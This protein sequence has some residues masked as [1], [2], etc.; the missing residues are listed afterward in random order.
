[1]L[2]SLQDT[3]PNFS[4]QIL[5]RIGPIVVVVFLIYSLFIGISVYNTASNTLITDHEQAITRLDAQLITELN[6]LLRENQEVAN[7]GALRSDAALLVAN[8]V[9]VKAAVDRLFADIIRLN[10]NDY[11]RVQYITSNGVILNEVVNERG[12]PRIMGND[13]LPRTD[14]E[15][16]QSDSFQNGLQS[17][18]ADDFYISDLTLE[19]NADG[20]PIIPL[21]VTTSVYVPV[22]DLV[23]PRSPLGVVRFVI[24]AEPLLQVV[25]NPILNENV[26]R[27]RG[28]YLV[29]ELG[30]VI[31]DS[32]GQSQDYLLHLIGREPTNESEGSHDAVASFVGG[33]S[34]EVTL[35]ANNGTL[36]TVRNFRLGDNQ[37]TTWKL[38]VTEPQNTLLSGFAGTMVVILV[39]SGFVV[40]GLLYLIHHQV[41]PV[42]AP[43]MEV[44]QQAQQIAT[45]APAEI[46]DTVSPRT[47]GDAGSLQISSALNTLSDRIQ[48]LNSEL[49]NQST[50]YNRDMQIITNIGRETAT[51]Y[52]I[53]ALMQRSIE[54]ICNELGFYHAQIFLVDDVRVNAVLVQ[55]RGE[56]GQKLLEQGHKLAVGSDSII[57]QVT[58]KGTPVIV[59]D[60][61][62]GSS[63]HGFNPFLPDTRAE[64]ALPLVIGTDVIGAL[65][66]QSVE[67]DVF[68]EHDL[69]TFQLVADQLAVAIHNAQLRNQSNQ[70]IEQ[71]N[72]LNRQL[73]RNSWADAQEAIGF[74]FNY[75]YNLMDIESG[76]IAPVPEGG[77]VAPIV[78]RGEVI[79]TLNAT[80]PEG[81]S[82][83]EGH[84]AIIRAVA[85]R[86]ALA[87]EN[88]RLFQETQ[89]VLSETEIL[90][91][92]SRKLSE[93]G[94]YDDV[95]ASIMESVAPNA[96][97]GGIWIFD[98]Y[99][100]GD[101]PEWAQLA[102]ANVLQYNDDEGTDGSRLHL[103]DYPI[104]NH[105]TGSQILTVPDVESHPDV[106]DNFYRLMSV[107]GAQSIV[108]IPL[109]VRGQWRGFMTIYFD[110]PQ[111]YSEREKRIYN[112]LIDQAGVTIDNRLLL[113]QTESAL[114]RNAKLYTSSRIINTAQSLQDLVYAAIAMNSST[115]V[116][117]WLGILDDVHGDV[118]WHCD[119]RIIARS[120]MGEVIEVDELH[121]ID[122]PAS[123]PMIYGEPEVVTDADQG[124]WMWETPH[125][126]VSAFPL[127]SDN[128][129]IALFFIVSYEDY[130]LSEEDSEVYR[131]LTGQMSTQVQNSRLLEQTE[132]A[133]AE[134]QRLYIAS[135]A[136]AGATDIDSIFDS[137]AGHLAMPFLQNAGD[138]QILIHL[139]AAH[140]NPSRDARQ[141]LYRYQWR[142]DSDMPFEV[143][144]GSIVS[145]Q[146]APFAQLFDTRVS[147]MSYGHIEEELE[148]NPKL[149][150][151]LSHDGAQ[152]AVVAVL[153]TRQNW[154]G[155]LVCK[156]NQPYTFDQRY[157]EFVQAVANQIAIGI[158]NQL[159]FNAAQSERERLQTI[160][161][162]LPTGVIV[163]DPETFVPI[164]VNDIIAQLFGRDVDM[165]Q[166]F[167]VE[168]YNLYRTGT[169]TFYPEGE[170]PIFMAARSGLSEMADDL[171]MIEEDYHI[172]LLLNAAPIFD[173]DGNQTAIVAAFQDIRN[174]RSLEQT[175]QENLRTTISSY[176]AQRSFAQADT[177]DEVINTIIEQV[178]SIESDNVLVILSDEESGQNI[179]AHQSDSAIDDIRGL[180]SVLPDNNPVMIDNI[181]TEDTLTPEAKHLFKQLSAK[182]VMILP[183]R[184][185]RRENALGWIVL[186]GHRAN[187][188]SS[189]DER[190]VSSLADMARTAI[191]NRYLVQSTQSAL[192]ETRIL[193]AATTTI[194]GASDFEELGDAIEQSIL[195]LQPDMYAAF[196]SSAPGEV[197][198]MF[199]VGFEASVE[200][201]M[202]LDV[203]RTARLPEN[204][205]GVY[206]SDITRTTLGDFEKELLN[207]KGIQSFAAV[208]LRAKDMQNGRILLGFKHDRRFTE[209]ETRYL[210]SIADSASVVIDNQTLLRQIQSTLQETSVL[211]QSSRAL[212]DA[213]TPSEI[214]DVV[215]NY[216]I[217]PHVNQVFVAVLN[218]RSWDLPGATV[219]IEAGWQS[220][221]GVN[222]EGVTLSADQFP[223]WEQ[224]SHPGILMINDIYDE[225][226]DLDIMQRTSIE[227]L[228]TRS[229]VIIPLRVYNRAIGSIWIG[230]RDPYDYSDADARIFQAFAESASLSLEA[231]YLFAQTEHRARQ[232]ETSAQVGQSIGQILDLNVLLPEVVDLIRE[233]FK[234]DHVQIFLMDEQDKYAVLEA[235]TGE[236]GR[237]LLAMNHKLAKGSKSVIGQVTATGE[238][239][240]ALDT[241][242]ANV[243][244]QPNQVLPLTRSEMALPLIVK[245]RV[246]G[247]L[248]VQSNQP[249]A[250]SDE[251]IRALTTLA[252][253]IAIAIDNA[254]LY[255]EIERRA[256]DMSLLFETSVIA[257]T[258][259]TL[260]DALQAVTDNLYTALEASAV[261]FYL[262]QQ[263]VNYVVLKAV[264][265]SGSDQPISELSE[266]TVGDSE[267]LIGTVGNTLSS[268]L[269]SNINDEVRYLSIAPSSSTAMI[270]PISSG[271]DLIGLIV[272]EHNR[273]NAFTEEDLQLVSTLAGSLGAIVENSQLLDEL[274]KTN[275]QLREVDRLKSQFLANM[276][277]ELRTPLNSII[278]FSRVMLKGI[279]GALTEM[280]EQDLTTIYNSG[281]HLL[282]LI[283]DILDQAKIESGK[284]DL[285]FAFFGVKT[286]IESVRSIGIGLVKEKPVDLLIDLESGLPQAYGDEFRTRQILLNIVSNASKFTQDGAI[287]IRAYTIET[288]TGQ[289]FIRIDVTDTG[290]GID[291][292]DIPLLFET[293]RQVDSSLTRTVGGT[294]LGLPLSKS[295][296]EMQGGELLVASEVGVGSTFSVTLPTEEIISEEEAN[297]D[298]GDDGQTDGDVNETAKMARP[299]VTTQAVNSGDSNGQ[300]APALDKRVITQTMKQTTK[301]EIL[302]IEDNKDMVDQYRRLLQREGFEVQTA[303]HPAYA[304]AMVSNLRPTVLVMD[305]NFSDGEGWNILDRLKQRDDTFDI[306]VVICS[307]DPDSERAYQIG[308]HTYVHRPFTNEE[309][310]E[311]VLDA[312]KES[313]RERILII[314]D[315]PESI[316]LLEELLNENGDYRIFSADN[317]TEGISLVARRQPDLI[318]L[319]LRM[320]EMDGFA[321][322]SELRS[323]PETAEIP[324]MIVTGDVDFSAD[325][326]N[327]LA[328]VH[329]LPKANISEEE[330]E[331]FISDI[332]RHLDGE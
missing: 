123:S 170:L 226:L 171:A 74:D 188:F 231:S 250:F 326:Q 258:S 318:I 111:T 104:F 43:I 301:R 286:L 93:S 2:Q 246:A 127:F 185:P 186:V 32:H 145:S 263:Y 85:D 167:S 291:E 78:I 135:R 299:T 23:N 210:S 168:A 77:I 7:T 124:Q 308:A 122:V 52:D 89:V 146:D 187:Q 176:E 237:Q 57:G 140:P 285:K 287:T 125:S 268:Q 96:K 300:T 238:P 310:V 45:G 221:G 223:A 314:D 293:F 61:T 305:V 328:N 211:Y 25:N 180:N 82:F 9:E 59:N 290:I 118:E 72:S 158:E 192:Q 311:A 254:Y 112:A 6:F 256:S 62:A 17:I 163:L 236:P 71:I 139:I 303:D 269:V 121:V 51:L 156:S 15:I 227:S 217:G 92:L 136:I 289:T 161:S 245:G 155:V 48:N 115:E 317:G 103:T 69:P 274:Q 267:N 101:K 67:P 282:N 178:E 64:M 63:I 120:E 253:Q 20:E 255:E 232:L 306:P 242:D 141:M 113:E 117:F 219:E 147:A 322:L 191:D 244:H 320:P 218:R 22:F 50:R 24:D 304:E 49:L 53:D 12:T 1:M 228:D 298:D 190:T 40:V 106:E 13:S 143:P 46:S 209:G 54:L 134:T 213:T 97:G 206:I 153:Q 19:L 288:E 149:Q 194:T 175:L 224:L 270:S 131:A 90:Y 312:E 280:Q 26:V 319:D 18:D 173:N 21:R 272:V 189:A 107:L 172:D 203:L 142:S 229:L 75:S 95:V 99:V 204:T 323:N 110:S 201:G 321:V 8:D 65:D 275:E 130:S 154:Y 247:A 174:L 193:Y 316:R 259:E 225:E 262:P 177:L 162:T 4:Q 169:D 278:G 133:L 3:S 11:L 195:A 70:R 202:D 315:Q 14:V 30:H 302:L 33:L 29:D 248:D 129:P 105:L 251:D 31:A 281:Q 151:V 307:V 37:S 114:E 68:H 100:I 166:P 126:F 81:L 266:V 94:S 128:R 160:L 98:N 35:F 55:S 108:F 79:G 199:N 76:E 284:M 109:S 157:I 257:T 222:L 148:D 309:I 273:V 205:D 327:Q 234:Y 324:V 73:T 58:S 261:V 60:T 249:N 200:N 38:V 214:I 28:Y 34:G 84:Q 44:N 294:G 330:F 184:V 297:T 279:D 165:T 264:A 132:L 271:G 179:L 144:T 5:R 265:M 87:I 182:S 295:L 86:V 183:M 325:E 47:G 39:V 66:I 16:I 233:Q 88:A 102:T 27:D 36:Y 116:D 10:P 208:N 212:T 80:P 181:A 152:S 56:P 83:S 42:L 138:Q 159:L 215:I 164:L 260:T 119:L 207:G 292:K 240:I 230:S 329:V 283:N 331:Q 137:A 243:V 277:H 91:E 313:Q 220:D 332:R 239:S 196:L 252:G 216:L 235:S 198:E 150:Q 241:A 41:V 197:V 276:S 296:A